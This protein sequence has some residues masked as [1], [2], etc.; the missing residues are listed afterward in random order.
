MSGVLTFVQGNLSL[1]IAA[2]LVFL[3]FKFG[4]RVLGE[5][6]AGATALVAIALVLAAVVVGVFR[7][8]ILDFAFGPGRQERQARADVV[9]Y[10][11]DPADDPATYWA[12][13]PARAAAEAVETSYKLETAKS[14]AAISAAE[15]ERL[16]HLPRG[17]PDRKVWDAAGEDPCQGSLP[18]GLR[19]V[20][21]A[22]PEEALAKPLG[23]APAEAPEII[24]QAYRLPKGFYLFGGLVIL[25]LVAGWA[26][27]RR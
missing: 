24:Q 8:A 14:R 22:G 21:S 26:L 13:S 25:I 2:V 19:A 5:G 6:T 10:A 9:T 4:G 23:E 20:A 27:M 3:V 12:S 11:L 18:A 15:A 7:P 1:I 16:C 17:H